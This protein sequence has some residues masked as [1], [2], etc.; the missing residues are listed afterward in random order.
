MAWLLC[1]AWEPMFGANYF[2]RAS[3]VHCCLVW[4]GGDRGGQAAS[5]EGWRES[6]ARVGGGLWGTMLI[7]ALQEVCFEAISSKSGDSD[8]NWF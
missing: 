5:W 3:R 1:A 2:L 7:L 4:A 6:H 8:F